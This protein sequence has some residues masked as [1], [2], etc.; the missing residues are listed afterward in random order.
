MGGRLRKTNRKAQKKQK[1]S[2][3]KPKQ[4]LRSEFGGLNQ[5]SFDEWHKFWFD[6]LNVNASRSDLANDYYQDILLC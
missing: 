1:R 4:N 3:S 2:K 6:D 5:V